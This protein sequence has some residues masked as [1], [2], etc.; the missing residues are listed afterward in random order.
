MRSTASLTS[1]TAVCVSTSSRN[2]TSV[3]EFPSVIVEVTFLTPLMLD[4]ASS[5][6]LVTCVSSSLGATPGSVMITDTS[7]TSIFGKRVT[8]SFAKLMTPRA[9]ST[10]K[11]RIGGIGFRIDQ[12]EMFQFMA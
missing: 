11:S 1:V 6:R 4:T 3:W 7:G 10:R 9:M 2:S 12:A 8:G 5:I